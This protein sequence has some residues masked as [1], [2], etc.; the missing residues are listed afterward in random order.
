MTLSSLL[1]NCS[2]VPCGRRNPRSASPTRGDAT[3]NRESS[4]FFN[5]RLG[6]AVAAA[7]VFTLDAVE[8]GGEARP[9]HFRKEPPLLGDDF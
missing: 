9:A 8:A 7:A 5:G 6:S 4:V 2:V 3:L 1:K